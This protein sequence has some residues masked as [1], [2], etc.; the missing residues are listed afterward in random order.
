MTDQ[1]RELVLLDQ[2]KGDEP[3]GGSHQWILFLGVRRNGRVDATATGTL[4]PIVLEAHRIQKSR[5]D[6]T[7][8]EFFLSGVGGWPMALASAAETLMANLA[9]YTSVSLA[10]LFL[11]YSIH[12]LSQ[13]SDSIG[14]SRPPCASMRCLQSPSTHGER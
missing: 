14:D 2:A 11:V 12:W 3:S 7:P 8:L 1:P 5:G 9:A 10:T 13:P 4:V 6:R